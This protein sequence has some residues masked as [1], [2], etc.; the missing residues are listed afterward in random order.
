[1]PYGDKT[2]P[3]GQG[4]RTGRGA[5]LCAGSVVPGNLNSSPSPGMGRGGRGGF[6]RGWRHRFNA[7][8]P[9]GWQR[10]SEAPN[11]AA[12]VPFAPAAD[13]RQIAALKGQTESLQKSLNQMQKRIEELETRQKPE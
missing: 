6:G 5:G 3:L 1:M 2:G 8:G 7:T 13:E 4:P 12:P 11:A 10:A 9:R